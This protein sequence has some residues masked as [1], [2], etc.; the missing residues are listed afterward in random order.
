MKNFYVFIFLV[1]S[2]ISPQLNAQT[3][4]PNDLPA[5]GDIVNTT[6]LDP[7]AVDEGMA[8]NN[9]T[10][11]F[12]NLT[13]TPD[14][15]SQEYIDPA[16]TPYTSDYPSANLAVVS[17]GGAATSYAYYIIQSGDFE[18]IG[19]ASD[20]LNG[21]YDDP[22]LLLSTPFSFGDQFSDDFSGTTVSVA[23]TS[24]FYGSKTVEADANG[25]LILPDVTFDNVL[26]VKMVQT[27]TDSF[28]IPGVSTAITTNNT[29]SYTWH[30]PGVKGGIMT[31]TYVDGQSITIIAGM[32]P[33]ITDLPLTEVASLNPDASVI[34]KVKNEFNSLKLGL[35]S[36]TPATEQIEVVVDTQENLKAQVQFVNSFGQVISTDNWNLMSGKQNKIV[37]ISNLAV[38]TYWLYVSNSKGS[39]KISFQ[40]I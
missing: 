7:E 12:S 32:D 37:D 40:K 36:A 16:N 23:G 29:T 5:I 4:S 2:C 28:E 11:D 15:F 30:A 35:N 9:V 39:A 22:D 1:I 13:I 18:L 8:G 38:G 14:A 33:I 26:R 20:Q 17:G 31:I 21:P 25:T 10:W 27:R 24:Y 34:S 3:I 19:T 6:P